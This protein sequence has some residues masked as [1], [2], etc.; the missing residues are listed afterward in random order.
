MKRTLINPRTFLALLH[1]VAVAAIAWVAAYALRFN[2]AIPLEIF[3]PMLQSLLWIVPL[4][5]AVFIS[6]GLYR[7]VWRFASVLDLKR[8]LFAVST[9]VAVVAAALFM[10]ASEVVVPRSVLILDPI[11][12]MLM[13]GGSRFVYRAWKEHQLYSSHI[14]QGAP[15]IIL[16]A[17]DAAVA[18]VKDLARSATWRV[19]AL[20]DDDKTMLGREIYG[21]KVQGSLHSLEVV[22]ERYDVKHVIIAMPS[23]HHQNRR[24]AIELAN[25]LGLAVLTVPAIDDLM[26]GK[27]SISQIRRVDVEDLLGRDAV[28]LDNSGLH[29]LIAANTVLVSGAGGSIG[30]ELCRQI[31]KYQPSSLVCLDLS[32]YALYTLEQELSRLNVTTKLLYM[33]GDVK[34]SQRVS[35]LLSQYQPTVVFHAA[36]YKHVPMMENG[37][38]W[39]ALSNNVIGTYTLAQACKAAHVAKF[40][41]ISTDKAV[42]PTNVMGASKRL[43]EMVCQG[44]QGA[45]LQGSALQGS[46]VQDSLP[47][48]TKP[49]TKFV[50]V[51]FGNVLGSSGSVIP[52]FREQIAQGGPITI[53]HQDITRYFMSIPEA[54]QLVMQAGLMGRGG[55]IFVLDM[56]E[57]VKIAALA[58]D[59]IRLSGLQVEDIKIEYIGLR[60]GEKLYEEL[61]ADDEHTTPTPHEKLRIALA[62]PVDLL[63]V[64]N[65]L[66]WINGV[67]GGN[68]SQIK[69][70]LKVWVEEYSPQHPV[71][72]EPQ[73]SLT[74]APM[75]LH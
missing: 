4:Q 64:D 17:G 22:H 55:E 27:V 23:A 25:N 66:T 7:G 53:T 62:R 47:A 50:I 1:D 44:L 73:E 49:A 31:L 35:D 56:G 63:W 70:E 74:A 12:L 34:N 42:N 19:V 43:A 59:M 57:P 39:E 3:Q 48:A 41:L 21:V 13:M 29:D 15:V 20:L 33:T 51:R 60:P 5:G 28:K 58:A 6:L 72:L 18:L 9:A 75:T 37:N 30:S 11:L 65:L 16:G 71:G 10:L 54:A 68:E 26:S 61:L 38:V 2:F 14:N 52:K 46:A 67:Q 40:V 8:I 45:V 69:N 24:Q 36:A 32:E